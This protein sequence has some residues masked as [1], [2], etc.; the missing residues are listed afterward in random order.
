MLDQETKKRIDNARNILVGKIPN[1][2]A[3]VEQITIALIYKFMDDMDRES[4]EIGGN[5]Q[6]FT[7]DFMKY[8]WSE[9]MSSKMSGHDRLNLYMETLTKMGTNPNVPQLFR[10]IFKDAFLPYRD[11]ETLNLFL[12][13]INGFVYDHSER[14]GDAYEYLLS[15]LGSQGDAGQFRTPRHII[16]FIVKVIDPQKDESVLD[17]ACGTAGFLISA[18]KHILAKNTK[19]RAGDLLTPVERKQVMSQIIGYDISPNMMQLALVNMYLHS[20][21]NPRIIEYDTL[22]SEDNWE[23]AYDVILANPPFMTPKGGIRPHKR[24]SVQANRSEVLFVDYIAEHLNNHGRAGIIVPEGIIFQSAT[25]YKALRKYLVE[26]NYLWAVVS[27][28]AGVF[29]PY[30]GVK[31]SI[32][33]L[34]KVRA[35]QTDEVL[36]LKISND[37]YDL[38][39][40]R[41]EIDK[42]DLPEALEVLTDWKQGIKKES[43]I[44]LWV[45]QAKLAEDADY[46][47]SQDRYLVAAVRGNIKYL[48]VQLKEVFT[49]ITPP[50]KLQTSDFKIEGKYPIVDQSQVN[51]SGYSDDD[52]AVIMNGLPFIV[53]GDHTCSVKF[54]TDPFIQGADGIKILAPDKRLI[55]K[56]FYYFLKNNPVI[57]DGYKRHF[58]KLKEMGM[59]LPPLDVQQEIVAEIEGY[60]KIIDGARQIVDNWKPQIEIDPEWPMVELGEVCTKVTDGSHFSPNTTNEGYSYI[61]VKDLTDGVIDFKCSKKITK[62]DY[63]DLA[64]NGCNPSLNDILFSKDGTVGKTALV[65]FE[66]EFVVLSSLAIISP[67]LQ[68]IY[69]NYLYNIMSTDWFIDRAI[70]KKTGV[71]IKRIVLKTLKTIKV[72]MPELI[73]QKAIID[74]INIERNI[75]DGCKELIAVYEAKI[76]KVIDKVWG[77]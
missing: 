39:A 43:S 2:Q 44:A 26:N 77:E 14:L 32:L 46:N 60:Q 33:L 76:K 6:F 17:P 35:K 20:F 64:K 38:G 75:L 24:F 66:K 18:F 25:A 1:P 65:S 7:G 37:G 56:F 42:N 4:V 30:S 62:A 58:S 67:N 21:P 27:L 31:T 12:K 51:I 3:Q 34:D 15:I 63:L 72:P 19:D 74:K 47:F 40:Q 48:R 68:K 10:S 70:S 69:P 54:I 13:E 55:P 59:P 73:V 61:T 8:A 9:L 29:N 22:T 45:K 57:S 36:F 16:D 11:P 23:E 53:F 71:A 50:K 49:T 41:R 5:P 52:E 28:P